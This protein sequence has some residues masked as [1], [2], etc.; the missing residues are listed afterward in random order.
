[1][2]G[3]Y[4]CRTFEPP[5]C[6]NVPNMSCILEGYYP[7]RINMHYGRNNSYKAYE[8]MDVPGRTD[9]EIHIGNS[10]A[11]T[12]GCLLLG[13]RMDYMNSRILDSTKAFEKFMTAMGN[14]EGFITIKEDRGLLPKRKA[15]VHNDT[16]K[17]IYLSNSE[18]LT[19]LMDS[20]FDFV[21][22]L[23]YTTL[24]AVRRGINKYNVEKT[25]WERVGKRVLRI[26]EALLIIF[27][28]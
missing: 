26:V 10:L 23:V 18:Q 5:D 22:H 12:S 16:R 1:M 4:I 2:D 7:V 11:D 6:G 21:S 14:H 27:A 19:Y 17:L 25:W 13:M 24:K 8:I 15:G 9:I 3:V 28:K 20:Y